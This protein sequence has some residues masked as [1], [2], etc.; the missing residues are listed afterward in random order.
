MKKLLLKDLKNYYYQKNYFIFKLPA[1][2]TSK[3]QKNLK[4]LVP[5]VIMALAEEE[6]VVKEEAVAVAE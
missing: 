1:Q 5:V 4:T 6:V 2:T 3:K